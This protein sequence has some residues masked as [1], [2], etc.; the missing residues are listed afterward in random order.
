[1][2]RFPR[3]EDWGYTDSIELVKQLGIWRTVLVLAK[4][5]RAVLGRG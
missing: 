2:P 1:M 3:P 5:W 4:E